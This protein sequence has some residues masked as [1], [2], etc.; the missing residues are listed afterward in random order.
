MNVV[1]G[2]ECGDVDAGEDETECPDVAVQC[3]EPR[4]NTTPAHEA[5]GEGEAEQNTRRGEH[6]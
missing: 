2:D 6:P 1:V 4:R 3:Q 5:C